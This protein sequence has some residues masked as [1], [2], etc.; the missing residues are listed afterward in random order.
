MQLAPLEHSEYKMFTRRCLY[1]GTNIFLKDQIPTLGKYTIHLVTILNCPP[2]VYPNDQQV[3]PPSLNISNF[4]SRHCHHCPYPGALLLLSAPPCRLCHHLPH[5]FSQH[6]W[7]RKRKTTLSTPFN[8]VA[9]LIYNL[10]YIPYIPG[11]SSLLRV[12]CYR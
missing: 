8:S 1:H 5:P 4:Q 11:S 9:R 2:S 12:H 6:C 7:W 10:K 3:V